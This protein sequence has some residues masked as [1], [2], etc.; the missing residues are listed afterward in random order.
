MTPEEI[1]AWASLAG[2][3]GGNALLILGIVGLIKGWVVTS[4]HLADVVATKDAYIAHLE[5]KVARLQE[6]NGH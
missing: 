6:S 4:Q 1:A 3:V 2:N 5:R